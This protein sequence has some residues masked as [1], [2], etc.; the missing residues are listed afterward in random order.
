MP[1]LVSHLQNRRH[2]FK[3]WKLVWTKIDSCFHFQTHHKRSEAF[4][5]SDI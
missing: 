1:K 2:E 5:V 3:Q 4:F